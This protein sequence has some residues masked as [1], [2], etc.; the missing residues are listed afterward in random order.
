M[1]S[2][3]SSKSISSNPNNPDC[4]RAVQSVLDL[5]KHIQINGSFTFDQLL[6]YM[7]QNTDQRDA[8]S[9]EMVSHEYNSNQIEFD[10]KYKQL[11]YRHCITSYAVAVLDL[12]IGIMRTNNLVQLSQDDI[13]YMTSIGNKKTVSKAIKE[14]L[15]NGCIAIAIPG[16]TRRPTVYMVNPYIATSGKDKH[17][18]GI[19]WQYTGT[20]EVKIIHPDTGREVIDLEKS[21]PHLQWDKNESVSTYSIGYDK[22]ETNNGNLIFNKINEPK[23]NSKK[24]LPVVGATSNPDGFSQD[25]HRLDN[26]LPLNLY[27]TKKKKKCQPDTR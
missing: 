5:K 6:E 21:P 9:V 11:E 13:I 15:D 23:I 20:K 19:F 14:L 4:S 18:Y 10:K 12:M 24:G 2:T 25:V 8:A 1:A 16:N 17:L 3:N 27:S 7:Q 26:D 22:L